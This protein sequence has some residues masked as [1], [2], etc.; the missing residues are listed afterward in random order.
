MELRITAS[1][2]K[3][4]AHLPAADQQRIRARLNAYA[5]APE[6]AGHDVIMLVNRKGLMRLRVG[7]WRVIFEKREAITV[8]KV[9]HRR[10]AYR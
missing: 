10:E 1:A 8:L 3:Q 2:E 4:F 9:M 5:A 6:E 7:D